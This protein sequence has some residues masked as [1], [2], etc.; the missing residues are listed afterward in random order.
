MFTLPI[1]QMYICQKKSIC[2]L[3]IIIYFANIY[4]SKKEKVYAH[5]KLDAIVT[6]FLHHM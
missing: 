3:K 1:L 5:G 6:T 2:I 4:L